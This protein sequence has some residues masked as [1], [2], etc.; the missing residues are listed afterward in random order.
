MLT[1]NKPFSHWLA[2]S[3]TLKCWAQVRSP[4]DRCCFRRLV[5]E[6]YLILLQKQ[7]E[8]ELCIFY[9]CFCYKFELV[10]E[11]SEGKRRQIL[12]I[13]WIR[14]CKSKNAKQEARKQFTYISLLFAFSCL[15]RKM[16]CSEGLSEWLQSS[17][18]VSLMSVF[19]VDCHTLQYSN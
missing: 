9:M 15:A 10:F 6:S 4:V 1:Y 12:R 8:L 2:S 14:L 16:G 17:F 7:S 18:C 13:L 3:S 19:W 5:F 11:Q